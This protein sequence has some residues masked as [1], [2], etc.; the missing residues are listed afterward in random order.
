MQWLSYCW[1][2]LRKQL[3]V[4]QKP[5]HFS[6]IGR[7]KLWT[8][9][10]ISNKMWRNAPDLLPV[11]PSPGPPSPDISGYRKWPRN[12]CLNYYLIYKI[13]SHSHFFSEKSD[14]SYLGTIT[15]RSAPAC[16][17]VKSI[18]YSCKRTDIY[19]LKEK[20]MPRLRHEGM[21]EKR[22]IW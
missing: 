5:P 19:F 20:A 22:G 18:S 9:S 11:V 7:I 16:C 14:L 8:R 1:T 15:V 6:G 13:M 2:G 4:P 10:K 21:W 3:F 17:I 12:V